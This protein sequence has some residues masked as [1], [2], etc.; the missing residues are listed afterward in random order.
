MAARSSTIPAFAS[1]KTGST[2]KLDHGCSACSRRVSGDTASRAS[3]ESRRHWWAS[4]SG[5]VGWSSVRSAVSTASRL[6]AAGDWNGRAGV[7]SAIATPAIVAWT[8]DSNT[9]NHTARPST[10]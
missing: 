2:T 8:P 4:P 9:A 6:T 10:R 3:D 5:S 1:A 7:R